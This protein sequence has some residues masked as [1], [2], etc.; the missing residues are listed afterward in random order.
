MINNG[1]SGTIFNAEQMSGI[2]GQQ[3]V[4]ERQ[5]NSTDTGRLPQHEESPIT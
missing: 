1:A 2:I 4:R 5:I 3:T